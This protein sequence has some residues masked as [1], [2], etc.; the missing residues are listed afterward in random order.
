M[1]V[2]LSFDMEQIIEA[3]NVADTVIFAFVKSIWIAL[4]NPCRVNTLLPRLVFECLLLVLW[5]LFQL[6]ELVIEFVNTYTLTI[7]Y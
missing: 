7:I 2:C 5:Q 6:P 1:I 4:L 3:T